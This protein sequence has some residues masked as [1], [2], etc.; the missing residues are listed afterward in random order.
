MVIVELK[1]K[2]GELEEPRVRRLCALF[3]ETW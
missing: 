2:C 3:G 1:E